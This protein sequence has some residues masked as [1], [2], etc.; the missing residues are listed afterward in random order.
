MSA[1]SS[2]RKFVDQNRSTF[3]CYVAMLALLTAVSI[4][5]PGFGFGD[6]KHLRAL[7]LQAS[8][9]GLVSLGQT[10]VII[11]GGADLSLPW[12]VAGTAVMM[13]IF[14]QGQDEKMIWA[15]PVVLAGASLIG[16]INGLG[17]AYLG[18]APMVMTL[19]TNNILLGLVAGIGMGGVGTMGQ[20]GQP[21]PFVVKLATGTIGGFPYLVIIMVVLAALVTILLSHTGFGRRIYVI[22][23]NPTVARYSGVDV[24]GSTIGVYTLNGFL[25]GLAGIIMTGKFGRAYLGMGDPYL[26]V[27]F[28]AVIIGGASILGGSGSYVGTLGGAMLLAVL[29]SL[30]PVLNMPRSVQLIIYGLVVLFAVFFATHRSTRRA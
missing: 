20:Y 18:I 22:G 12:T 11:S 14:T 5:R 24:R 13:T 27:S 2:I 25:C 7:L 29:L 26:F 28:A 1:I 21:P 17:V 23:T 10:L 19:A 4:L 6:P 8:V 9:I 3:L 15:I 30:L 16:L